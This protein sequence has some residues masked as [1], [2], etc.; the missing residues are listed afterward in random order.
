V[1]VERKPGKYESRRVQL[2]LTKGKQVEVLSGVFPGDKV[3]V[4]G[5]YLL[6]SLLGNEHKARKSGAATNT[7][8]QGEPEQHLVTVADATVELPTDRQSFAGPRIEGRIRRVLVEPSQRVESGQI[9]A[10]VDSLQLRTVQLDLLQACSRLRLTQQSLDRLEEL[11]NR[12][13]T[14][15]RRIWELR[16]Q[17]DTLVH[18]VSSLKRQLAFFGLTDEE[19]AQLESTDVSGADSAVKLLSGVPVRAPAAGWIVG[20]HVVPGQVVHPEDQLFEV[21]DLS[22]VWV[23]GYVFE[24]DA[25]Q[26]AV[27]QPARVTFSAFPD[28]EAVGKVVRIAPMMHDIERVLPV[29]VEID[30]PDR[31]L[32]EGMLARVAVLAHAS[33]VDSESAK[34]AQL[35]PVQPQR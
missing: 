3:V 25:A 31:L 1:L 27:G 19:V 22:Q 14:P 35:R 28:L 10:E 24:R 23:K 26:V 11:G 32:K 12:K 34:T 30:N 18:Q 33:L 15:E 17:R 9:L 21:H 20:F 8:E 16:N 29:W 4:T 7:E 2:G 5:A 6:A 13:I